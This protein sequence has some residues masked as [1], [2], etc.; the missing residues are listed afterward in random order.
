MRT[1][2]RGE[3]SSDRLFEQHPDPN[4]QRFRQLLDHGD[5]RVTRTPL[6]IADIGA[7]DAGT[8]GIIFLA[9]ALLKSQATH[10]LTKAL[11]DIHAGQPAILSTIDLQTI[12]DIQLDFV[13][14]SS[15]TR[16]TV[17]RHGVGDE[18]FSR[19]EHTANYRHDPDIERCSTDV[20]FSCKA[21][22]LPI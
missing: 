15:S 3:P 6:D 8:V 18:T 9:P 22:T 13:A 17:S 4:A 20:S 11:L 14:W 5:G 7:V 19:C 1:V 12:S 16:V 21:T 2:T 10:V